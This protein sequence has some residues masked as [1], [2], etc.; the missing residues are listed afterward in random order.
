[1][2]EEKSRSPFDFAQ[3]RLC[4]DDNKKNND[5]GAVLAGR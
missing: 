4:G 3:S 1:M 5:K 2:A